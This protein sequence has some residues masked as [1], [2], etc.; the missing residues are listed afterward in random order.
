MKTTILSL[1]TTLTL[2]IMSTQAVNKEIEIKFQLSETDTKTFTTW[3]TGHTKYVGEQTQKECYLNNPNDSFFAMSTKGFIDALSCLRIRETNHGTWMCVK[4][5]N[6][7]PVTKK[8]LSKNEYETKIEDGATA[9]EGFVAIGFTE[10]IPV[11]K[12]RQIYTYGDFEIVMDVVENLGTFFEVELKDGSQ[13]GQ[14]GRARIKDFLKLTGLA[15]IEEF[16][17]SYIHMIK[18][19]GFKF[20]RTVTL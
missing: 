3:L 16:E 6:V 18:N 4:K 17:R 15:S 20:S 10:K 2:S 12:V 7:D 5:S 11:N 1:M 14:K 19:P 8:I 13:D 9:I